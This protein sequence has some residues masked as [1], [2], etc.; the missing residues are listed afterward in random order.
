MSLASAPLNTDFNKTGAHQTG[1]RSYLPAGKG[2]WNVKLII[3][4][5]VATLELQTVIPLIAK[6]IRNQQAR[7]LLINLPTMQRSEVGTT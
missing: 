6:V 3:R 2:G 4:N 5:Y 1:I 7:W